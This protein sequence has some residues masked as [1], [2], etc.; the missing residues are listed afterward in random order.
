MLLN[1]TIKLMQLTQREGV[2][3]RLINLFAQQE[4]VLCTNEN[5]KARL[6]CSSVQQTSD[7]GF[8]DDNISKN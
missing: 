3:V 6:T 2:H 1:E 5:H 7:C 4:K 8:Y